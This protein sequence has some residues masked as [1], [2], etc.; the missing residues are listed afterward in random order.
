MFN[1]LKLKK[2]V[3]TKP[4]NGKD[5]SMG[6]VTTKPEPVI[7]ILQG[8]SFAGKIDMYSPTWNFMKDHLTTHLHDLRKRNDNVQL[9]V[10]KTQVIRGQIKE[11]KLLLDV[12]YEKK[13]S[14]YI[15]PK[16]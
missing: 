7:G 5:E 13:K 10:E 11:I 12:L 15:M 8:Q 4:V 3:K 6:E 1:F 2:I 9:T 14:K 16:V